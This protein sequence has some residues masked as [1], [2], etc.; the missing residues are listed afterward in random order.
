MQS[1]HENWQEW[2]QYLQQ[3]GLFGIFC[4]LLN[5]AEPFKILAAQSLWLSQPFIHNSIIG[6][7]ADVLSDEKQSQ[8]FL[9]F[10]NNKDLHE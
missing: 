5:A 3:K 9:N 2:A 6:Q 7:L 4:F 8:E 1:N 10:V